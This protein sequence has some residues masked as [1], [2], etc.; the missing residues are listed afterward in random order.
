MRMSKECHVWRQVSDKSLYYWDDSDTCPTS[1]RW[2]TR[3]NSYPSWTRHG[4]TSTIIS[5]R[6]HFG[7]SCIIRV[8][9]Q[10]NFKSE[11]SP[12]PP[13]PSHVSSPSATQSCCPVAPSHPRAT[14]SAYP[15]TSA[16]C[17]TPCVPPTSSPTVAS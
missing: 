10:K 13:L 1:P 12:P 11:S 9:C 2:S 3:C 6:V 16:P 5:C 15:P 7:H 8:E 17:T 4:L 14:P